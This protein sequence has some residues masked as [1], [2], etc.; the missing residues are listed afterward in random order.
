MEQKLIP[1]NCF[2]DKSHGQMVWI[3]I[4][5]GW[6]DRWECFTCGSYWDSHGGVAKSEKSCPA[7]IGG[8]IGN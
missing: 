6:Q 3:T 5:G 4:D 8:I 1:P 7:M 2:I